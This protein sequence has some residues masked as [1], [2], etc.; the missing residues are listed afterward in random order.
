MRG[1]VAQKPGSGGYCLSA[2]ENRPETWGTAL[3][4]IWDAIKQAQRERSRDGAGE[5]ATGR[6]EGRTP[7]ERRSGLRHAHEAALLVYG[8]GADKQPFH[9]EA[10]TVDANENGCLLVLEKAV[11]PGQR[12]FLTNVRNQAEQECRV[13]H[14]GRRAR[15][16]I[17]VGVEFSRAARNF[18][19][20]AEKRQ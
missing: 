3:S 18:W 13:V 7:S 4:R 1:G 14:V 11:A 2:G 19:K 20:P 5:R 9:E 12:L 10:Q 16:K 17:R 15:G 8:S 6:E